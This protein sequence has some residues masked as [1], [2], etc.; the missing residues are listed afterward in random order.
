MSAQRINALPLSCESRQQVSCA[1][2]AR[3]IGACV[4]DCMQ[5]DGICSSFVMVGA[6]RARLCSACRL[7][8]TA[9][10]SSCELL[11]RT[12]LIQQAVSLCQKHECHVLASQ[13]DQ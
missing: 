4:L 9:L 6:F 1:T 13:R 12:T 7:R 8:Y 2:V 3:D 11:L 5:N 10:R